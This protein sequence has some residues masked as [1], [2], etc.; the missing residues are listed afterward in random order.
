VTA[1]PLR[2]VGHD[3][4]GSP[5]SSSSRRG[6]RVAAG[7]DIESPGFEVVLGFPLWLRP[8]VGR[9]VAGLTLGRRVYLDTSVVDLPADRAVAILHHEIT[10]VNQYRRVGTVPF[11]VRYLVE[12]LRNRFRGMSADAAYRE[13]SFEKEAFAEELMFER[14]KTDA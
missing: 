11:L 14:V 7:S 1:A 10:H 5:V 12:Y 13:I 4:S 3:R 2:T 6:D 9:R 8:L